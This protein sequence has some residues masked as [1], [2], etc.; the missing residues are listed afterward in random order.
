[1]FNRRQPPIAEELSK[2]SA[3]IGELSSEITELR[4]EQLAFQGAWKR[5]IDVHRQVAIL[6]DDLDTAGEP[7]SPSARLEIMRGWPADPPTPDWVRA[8]GDLIGPALDTI[9]RSGAALRWWT[10]E[11]AVLDHCAPAEMWR[12]DPSRVVALARSLLR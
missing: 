5:H 4:V 9:D 2:L 6:L 8:L 12:R 10:S 1:M 3:G 11:L 7:L